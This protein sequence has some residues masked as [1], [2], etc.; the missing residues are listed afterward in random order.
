MSDNCSELRL[1]GGR[2]SGRPESGRSKSRTGNFFMVD[3][4]K[5]LKALSLGFNEATVYLLICN[6]TAKDNITSSWGATACLNH[7]GLVPKVAKRL[8]ANL[9]TAKLLK[10]NKDKRHPYSVVHTK[11]G[12]NIWLPNLLITGTGTEDKPLTRIRAYDDAIG[13]LKMLLSLYSLQDFDSEFGLPP[14]VISRKNLVTSSG[15]TGEAAAW[16][17]DEYSVM[18]GEEGVEF[19]TYGLDHERFRPHLK[20][21]ENEGLFTWTKVILESDCDDAIP[22]LVLPQIVKTTKEKFDKVYDFN[23]LVRDKL[24]ENGLD[25]YKGREMKY[26]EPIALPKRFSKPRIYD[27]ITLRY[28]AK[29]TK[30][31]RGFAVVMKLLENHLRFT[32]RVTTEYKK[33]KLYGSFLIKAS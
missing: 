11:T 18:L 7:L 30:E 16:V 14:A 13:I 8:I 28:R 32:E 10:K 20:I 3:E 4:R 31:L 5:L 27:V 12:K 17:I 9:I 21:L 1:V 33:Q 6:G 25:W 24:I 19:L 26:E 2:G 23:R 29:T 22:Y 15:V